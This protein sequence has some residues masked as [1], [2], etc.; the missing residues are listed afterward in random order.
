MR[1]G[2]WLAERQMTREQFGALVGVDHSAV[3]KWVHGRMPRR[4]HLA[5]IRE[6]TGGLVTPDDFVEGPGVADAPVRQAG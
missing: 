6:A 5:K 2:D 3:T 4:E 1:L